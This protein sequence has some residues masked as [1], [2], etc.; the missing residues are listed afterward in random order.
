MNRYMTQAKRGLTP[1]RRGFSLVELLF[2][3][4]I[5]AVLIGIL[6]PVVSR[7]RLSAQEAGVKNQ[8]QALGAQCQA[9]FNIHNAYPGPLS[10]DQ[11]YATTTYPLPSGPGIAPTPLALATKSADF[12]ITSFDNRRVTAMENMVLGLLGGLR[13]N[14]VGNQYQI[15]YDPSLVGQ[16]PLSLNPNDVKKY[17]A[18]GDTK[19]LSFRTENN[20]RTGKYE[21]D[22]ASANDTHIPE[23]LDQF[24]NGMPILYLRARKGVTGAPNLCNVIRNYPAATTDPLEMY[25]LKDIYGYT[26]PSV[27]GPAGGGGGYIGEGKTLPKGDIVLVSGQFNGK[28]PHGLTTV[29]SPQTNRGSGISS[30]TRVSGQ[31]GEFRTYYYPYDAYCYFEDPANKYTAGTGVVPARQGQARAKD[32]FILISAGRDRVYGTRD[33]IASFGN[34]AP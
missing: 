30:I 23:I 26:G 5:I 28:I 32:T 9:Y 24:P 2:V 14:E 31:T 3:I 17:P 29:K 10:D 25:D 11:V 22:A 7:V 16:G 13:L 19:Y 20:K 21:D 33:D 15:V 12:D 6:V 34:V 18:L 4:G 1:L 8:I 27:S